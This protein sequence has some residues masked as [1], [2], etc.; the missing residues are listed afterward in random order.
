MAKRKKVP[1]KSTVFKRIEKKEHN[2]G[3]R[4]IGKIALVSLVAYI[5]IMLVFD[6]SSIAAAGLNQLI[7]NSIKS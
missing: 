7:I 6:Y 2:V 3:W 1:S 5:I 4:T